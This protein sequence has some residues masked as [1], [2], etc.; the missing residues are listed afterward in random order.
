[1]SAIYPFYRRI[2]ID[3]HQ[4]SR[5]DLACLEAWVFFRICTELKKEMMDRNQ[6]TFP[7]FKNEKE[8][9]AML[10]GKFISDI[11][12]QVLRSG[13]YDVNGMACYTGAPADIIYGLAGG[14]HQGPSLP[15]G[16]KIIELH[17]STNPQLY[18]RIFDTIRAQI[19]AAA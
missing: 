2:G 16:M 4:L 13:E 15:L 19:R 10:D 18:G 1:M 14:Y 3:T 5:S 12:N 6:C 17:F 11:V 7:D 9:T 8:L